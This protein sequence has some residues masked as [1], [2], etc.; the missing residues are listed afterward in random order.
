MHDTN[1]RGLAIDSSTIT[2]VVT[3]VVTT[4]VTAVVTATVVEGGDSG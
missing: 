2:D 3:A 4:I 1:A